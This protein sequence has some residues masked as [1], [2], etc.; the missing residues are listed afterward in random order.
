MEHISL[1]PNRLKSRT[2]QPTKLEPAFYTLHMIAA[3]ALLDPPTT[4][5]IRTPRTPL[6]HYLFSHLFLQDL[7][8]CA[9]V[10]GSTGIILCAGFACVKGIRRVC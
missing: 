10:P 8:F 9:V 6:F 4:Y 1:L 3:V 2:A 5:R 7:D